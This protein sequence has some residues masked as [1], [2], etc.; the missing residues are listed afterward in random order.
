M[1]NELQLVRFW[2]KV[3]KNQHGCWN[4]L[5]CKAG[6]G[7]GRFAIGNRRSGYRHFQAHRLSYELLIEPIQAG[8][9]LD[10]LCRNRACV[11][12]AHLEPVTHR[13]NLRRGLGWLVNTKL[14]SAAIAAKTHCKHGHPLSGDNL[15][16]HN[17]HRHCRVCRSVAMA[18]SKA[19]RRAS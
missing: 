1:L 11:N 4:W 14:A 6:G 12:P 18:L 8:F 15:Y 13:E 9:D 17:G 7:Y 19:K 5:A 10:H 2:A 16:I 3:D